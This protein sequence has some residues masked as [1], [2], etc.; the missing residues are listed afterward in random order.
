MCKK[1]KKITRVD[2]AVSWGKKYYGYWLPNYQ[3]GGKLRN[4]YETEHPEWYVTQRISKAEIEKLKEEALENQYFSFYCGGNYGLAINQKLRKGYTNYIFPE[5]NLLIMQKVLDER[6]NISYIPEN[7]WGYR[8][9]D[10]N[11]LCNSAGKQN[12]TRGTVLE[13]K[14]YMGV[15]IVKSELIKDF[16]RY[17]TI[18]KIMI[19]KGAKGLYTNLISNRNREQEVLFARGTKLRVLFKYR[20]KRKILICKMMI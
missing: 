18:L 17:D 8:F 6:L 14:G 15:G 2:E 12:I 16:G 4:V 1:Y 13:D 7:I 5:N 3:L 11:D 19:P 20:G 9:V 10:Y